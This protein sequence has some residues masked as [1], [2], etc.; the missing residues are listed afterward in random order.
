MDNLNACK[1]GGEAE[2]KRIYVAN[3]LIG[4]VA[5]CTKCSRRVRLYSSRKNASAA[6]NRGAYTAG[7]MSS[8]TICW[9]CANAV[10]DRA[11]ARG[12]SWSRR[13]EPVKGWKA[14]RKEL[15]FND[16]RGASA[17]ESYIVLECP[18]FERG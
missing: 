18:Q 6:W 16:G 12:C 7:T 15:R 4:Y 8:K 1:C 13:F 17:N 14:I 3:R 2:V 10:P 9:E 11:G 5:Q